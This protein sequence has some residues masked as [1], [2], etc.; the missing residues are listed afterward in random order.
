LTGDGQ[1]QVDLEVNKKV[2]SI[3]VDTI[4]VAIGRDCNPSGLKV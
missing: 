2:K 4:M 3:V 1:K